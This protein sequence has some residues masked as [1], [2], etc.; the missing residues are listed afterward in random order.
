MGFRDCEDVPVT[1]A[2]G[3]CESSLVL[4]TTRGDSLLSQSDVTV[5]IP[6]LEVAAVESHD[7][8]RLS[9]AAGALPAASASDHDLLDVLSSRPWSDVPGC[10]A[11]SSDNLLVNCECVVVDGN[12]AA[13]LD[14]NSKGGS[15]AADMA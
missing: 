10:M 3:G 15:R 7:T 14:G 8:L 1:S 9:T 11:A 13:R 6:P 2:A 5:I 12:C 4:L